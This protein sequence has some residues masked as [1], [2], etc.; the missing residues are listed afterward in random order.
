M[1]PNTPETRPGIPSGQ[2]ARAFY[3]QAMQ[4]LDQDA[5]AAAV[6]ALLLQIART[7]ADNG[8]TTAASDCLEAIFALPASADTSFVLSEAWEVRGRLACLTGDLDAAADA[9]RQQQVLARE[10]GGEW[11][12]ALGDEHLATLDVVRS[13]WDDAI[14]RLGAAA[15]GFSGASDEAGALR[16]LLQLAT[17]CVDL[18]RWNLA[19][20]TLAD[21]VPRA[22]AVHDT[23]TL[24]RLELTRATMAIDRA[25]IERA[26][27]ATERALDLARRAGEPGLLADAVAMSS[28]VAREAGDLARA[29]QLLE[30]AE[31][32]ATSLGDEMLLGELACGR[33][34]VLARE[35]QH[36]LT[37][38]ALNRAY[39]ALARLLG[40]TGSV[41]RARRLRRLE[42]TFLDVTRRWAQRFEGV[43]PD[44]SGHVERVA[45]LT[46]E[47]AR[48]MGAD[49]SS[50]I[51]YRVG[52]YLHD[53]GKLAIPAAILN[54]RGRL[55]ADEW[56]AVKRHPVAGAELLAEA[57]FPWEVR[58]IVESHH[59]CWDGSGYPHGR[60]GEEIPMAARIFCVADVYDALITRRP[61]KH[62]LTR[63]DAV[64]VMRRDVGRQFDPAVFHVFEDVI[65]EG[66]PIPGITSAAT[67]PN[68]VQ[69]DEPLVDDAL[70]SVATFASWTRRASRLLAERRADGGEACLLLLDVDD[71]DRVNRTYG[72]L[73]G[74][75]VLWAVA[76][77][78]QR[79]VRSQD[80]VGRRAG[81][82]FVVYLPGTSLAAATE[83]AERL[84][85]SVAGLRCARRHSEDESIAVS[86]CL[87]IATAP[88]DGET[89]EALLATADRSIFRAKGAGRDQVAVADR[90]EPARAHA[91]LDFSAFVGREDELRLLTAQLDF[92][93]RGEPRLVGITGEAGVGKS[94][95]VRQLEP[96]VRL[97]AGW[98]VTGEATADGM[99]GPLAPWA[100]VIAQL[101]T[102]GGTGERVWPALS[103]WLPGSFGDVETEG[104]PPTT[105]LQEEIVAFVRRAARARPVV[106][107]MENMHHAA[108]ASWATLDALLAAVD[109]ERLLMVFTS[110][111][112]VPAGAGEWRRRL[113]QHARTTMVPLRRF[114][115]EDVRRWIRTVFRDAA[116]GDDVARW[117]HEFAEGIPRFVLHLLRAA[118]DDGT[119][120]YAGTRWEWQAPDVRGASAGLSW[121]MER[122]LERLGAPTR[123]VLA[124]AALLEP[125]LSLELL[126]SVTG[127]SEQDARVAM[128]EAI[129]ASV[130][131][132]V[133]ETGDDFA[134]RHPLLIEA[135]VRGTP[136]RERQ[137]VHDVA[138]R[139]LELRAPAAVETIAAHYHAAGNDGAALALALQSAER[140]L[141]GC[142]HD[143]ALAHLQVAQR[144]AGSSSEL[145]T[146]R[147]RHAEMAVEGGRVDQAAAMS[148]L[149]LEWL[150]RQPV[151][152]VSIRARRTREWVQWQ[153]GKNAGR[154]S[155]AMRSLLDDAASAV[156]EEVAPTA[157][158]AAEMALERAQWSEAD[159]LA[160]RAVDS[161]GGTV[162]AQA[163]LTS[164]VAR[165][166]QGQGDAQLVRDAAAPLVQSD[167][168]RRR[169]HALLATGDVVMRTSGSAEA[170]D[171]LMSAIEAA[172]AGHHLRL[173]AKVSRS[174]GLWRARQGEWT[175]AQQWLGDAER[176]FSTLESEP[177][178][179][180]TLLDG[181]QLLRAMGDRARAQAQFESVARRARDIEVRGME[182]AA[183][184]GAALSNGGPESDSSRARWHRVSELITDAPSS[185]WFP[186]RELVDAF[187]I[188]MLLAS[189]HVA[190]AQELLTSATERQARLDQFGGVWLIAECTTA[191]RRAGISAADDLHRVA[192]HQA[193]QLGF[194]ALTALLDA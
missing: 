180:A 120:W 57:D 105:R 73:Q 193:R 97:R 113:Q 93:S 50:L 10:A 170:E 98:M 132:R 31:R 146:I 19:E 58:P 152:S 182:L 68:P 13:A 183:I 30:D 137:R 131:I 115:L 60:A 78:L 184:A 147:V 42:A 154:S 46:C 92:A 40:Q 136:E 53:L 35:D 79:G 176:L 189:G 139:V 5:P 23:P 187:A 22:H 169:A 45:D 12:V 166:W 74:D 67:V 134:F 162:R 145:A 26:R 99:D 144:Y 21:A 2:R 38:T 185:W 157:L 130:L 14:A 94:A 186:G 54:K 133:G 135:S 118:C 89:L 83:I 85:E 18:K 81:D 100:G 65:R 17:L 61:F 125:S 76:K 72:R 82:E 175:E 191:L 129:G 27:L 179:I 48:R 165:C 33:V 75:D 32:Q 49:P 66:V 190:A 51:G 25:N 28:I 142:A 127:L 69:Q 116:P 4:D 44:T 109:D 114:A 141:S 11:L 90:G 70:T 110:R 39:R 62:A 161:A 59:E 143:L 87:A 164:A 167:D 91:A 111:P 192:R 102:L 8:H 104:A 181:A 178:R 148:D 37:L 15:K 88:D 77:V 24:A 138:A 101:V 119:I 140:M 174:L 107:V 20:Q 108:A 124:T 173:A 34:E 171:L 158:V 64:E 71:F 80:L 128:E 36:R 172:R 63:E 163:A 103:Q 6:G 155:E 95:L 29:L 43:D 106:V 177:D 96:E 121:V 9:F 56:A 151:S 7:H 156:S 168:P 117:L 160:R 126:V 122:R 41:E 3:E 159:A 1:T 84:R 149:A 153:R 188:Q 150:D 16:V 123:Q 47:I 86:A 112:E 52:A 194:G 55:T